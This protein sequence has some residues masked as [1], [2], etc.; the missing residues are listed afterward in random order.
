M[1]YE[2]EKKKNS[3]KRF[4]VFQAMWTRN[5]FDD[6]GWLEVGESRIVNKGSQPRDGKKIGQTRCPRTLPQMGRRLLA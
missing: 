6:I 5:Y 2:K 3:N 4:D 1:Y